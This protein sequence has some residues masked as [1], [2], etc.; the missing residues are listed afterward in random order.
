MKTAALL[1]VLSVGA[2]ASR[3]EDFSQVPIRKAVHCSGGFGSDRPGVFSYDMVV[4]AS[5]NVKATAS[6]D[7]GADYGDGTM[8]WPATQI[9]AAALDI[10]AGDSDVWTFE[11]EPTAARL[12]DPKPNV[13]LITNSDALL[14]SPDHTWSV[15]YIFEHCEVE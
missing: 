10:E 12:A 13:L 15:E 6:V 1:L 8:T 4:F 5:G 3:P 14:G 7:A 2:C 11:Y 9:P